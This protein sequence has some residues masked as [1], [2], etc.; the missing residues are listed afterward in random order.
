MSKKVKVVTK[1]ED[2]WLWYEK[3]LVRIKAIKMDCLFRVET[4]EGWLKGKAGD[5]LIEGIKG[6]LYPCDAEIFK[7]TYD[8]A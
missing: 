3:K 1:I 8:M 6:E 2:G 7:L 5:Y 4:M